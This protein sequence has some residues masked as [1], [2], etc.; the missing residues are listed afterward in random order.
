MTFA[1]YDIVS[2]LRGMDKNNCRVPFKERYGFAVMM[3]DDDA[4][5]CVDDFT[6][7]SLDSVLCAVQAAWA[8]TKRNEN[9]GVPEIADPLEGWICDPETFQ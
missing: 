1:R 4:Q 9:Y 3:N 8:Y 5:H 7:D 6:G 2:A